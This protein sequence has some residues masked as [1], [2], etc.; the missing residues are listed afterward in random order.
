MLVSKESARIFV[1]HLGEVVEYG[2]VHSKDIPGSIRGR[3]VRFIAE[4][5]CKAY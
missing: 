2:E 5:L 4:P 1:V 3:M